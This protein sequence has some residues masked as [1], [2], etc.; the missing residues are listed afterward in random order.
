MVRYGRIR[1]T[2]KPK[3]N[4]WHFG[5]RPWRTNIHSN[6]FE[7]NFGSWP[8]MKSGWF[9]SC[10][11]IVLSGVRTLFGQFGCFFMLSGY[12]KLKPPPKID[13]ILVTKVSCGA[14]SFDKKNN[15]STMALFFNHILV[16]FSPLHGCLR[17]TGSGNDSETD[18]GRGSAAAAAT[19]FLT[20]AINGS[21]QLTIFFRGPWSI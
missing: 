10:S 18:G 5:G 20:N 12:P 16:S 9:Q 7:R 8:S 6:F 11:C 19:V 13:N 3:T 14:R 4:M 1:M 17:E 2:V 21:K 15:N